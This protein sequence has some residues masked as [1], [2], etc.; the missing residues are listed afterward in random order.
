[1]ETASVLQKK[2]GTEWSKMKPPYICNQCQQTCN[3]QP[4]AERLPKWHVNGPSFRF[5]PY[6]VI[7]VT[8]PWGSPCNSCSNKCA[9]HYVTDIDALLELQSNKKAIRALPPSVLIEEAFKHGCAEG[10][11]TKNLAKKCCLSVEEVQMWVTHLNK[12]N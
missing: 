8:K 4:E 3:R 7:D 1:M 9:G 10:E 2:R 11:N 6:P 12:R 5:F